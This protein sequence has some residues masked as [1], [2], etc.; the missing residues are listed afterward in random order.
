VPDAEE[1]PD[2]DAEIEALW[3]PVPLGVCDIDGEAL[4][5]G[6]PDPLPD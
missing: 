3:V 6:V 5:L 2:N 4:G 1:E